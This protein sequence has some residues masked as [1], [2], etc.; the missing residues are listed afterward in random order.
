M[1][2]ESDVTLEEKLACSL[3]TNI[4]NLA[5]FH[6]ALESLKIGTFVGYFYPKQEMHELKI[7]QG[8]MCYDNEEQFEI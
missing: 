3:E 6:R 4:K 8:V 7:Y 2:L 1:T 5:K